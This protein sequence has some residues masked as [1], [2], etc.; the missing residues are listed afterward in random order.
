MKTARETA[1]SLA[2]AARRHVA[3]YIS[4]GNTE[5]AAAMERA[6]AEYERQ[7]CQA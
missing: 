7:A 3:R 2:A 6:A 1:L 5:R 4:Q